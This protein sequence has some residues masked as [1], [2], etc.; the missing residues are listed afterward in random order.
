MFSQ[1]NLILNILKIE[2]S[3]SV[4]KPDISVL[5]LSQACLSAA[6]TLTADNR[7]VLD[8]SVAQHNFCDVV[9]FSCSVVGQIFNFK[10][11]I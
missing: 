11:E 6:T 9:K 2:G 8:L 1:N 10:F 5:A 4:R 3:K 7:D